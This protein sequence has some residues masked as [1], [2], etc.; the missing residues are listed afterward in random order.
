MLGEPAVLDSTGT[1][2]AGLRRQALALLLYLAVHPD[3]ASAEDITEA[4]WPD[5]TVASAT[6]RLHT[7]AANLR[8][9]IRIAA[10]R[11]DDSLYKPVTTTRDTGQYRL[12]GSLDVDLWAFRDALA[13]AASD[14]G[15]REKHLRVAVALHTGPFADDG[16]S[17]YAWL[18]SHRAQ[19]RRLGAQARRGLA[20]LIQDEQPD[21]AADLRKTADQLDYR[22][23]SALTQE[24]AR[25]PAQESIDKSGQEPVRDHPAA[26]LSLPALPPH[27]PRTPEPEEDTRA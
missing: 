7:E 5:A 9:T 25:E 11:A 21:E 16:V 4:L 24:P 15:H 19:V 6:K 2:V 12:Q 14:P 26:P 23:P 8:R 1:P 27:H 22:S 10:G 3:G 17:G 13:R 18:A 20:A